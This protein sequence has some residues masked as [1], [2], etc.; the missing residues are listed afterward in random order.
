MQPGVTMLARILGAA[1]LCALPAVPALALEGGTVD[2]NSDTTFASVGS[3]VRSSGGTFSGVLIDS[4]HVL[5]AQHVVGAGSSPSQWTF[6]VNFDGLP[7]AERA[8]AVTRIVPAPDFVG[9]V[10]GEVARNDL[11]VL[12]LDRDVPAS[13]PIYALSGAPLQPA[14]EI[15][16]VGYGGT[17]ATVKRRGTNVVEFLDP[18]PGPGST[19]DVFAY[20][21]DTDSANQA[22]VVGGDSGS[23]V[24]VQDGGIWKL[25]AISTFSWTNPE[26]PVTGPARGGGGMI[27]SAYAPW[28]QQATAVPEPTTGAL[29]A[30]GMLLLV[31]CIHRLRMRRFAARGCETPPEIFRPA[32]NRMTGTPPAR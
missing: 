5:T 26:V 4:R 32:Q 1:L 16:L 7:A 11:T 18:A 19:P 12:E 31:A 29:F 22:T 25:A 14:Q 24:F 10:N 28:I 17:G 6:N 9:F 2:A 27:L 3:L 21:Y 13:I 8:F 23:P 20:D 30:A 15:T